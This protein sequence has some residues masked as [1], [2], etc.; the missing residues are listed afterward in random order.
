MFTHKRERGEGR[1][2]A[3]REEPWLERATGNW[4]PEKGSGPK[5]EKKYPFLFFESKQILIVV[6]KKKQQITSR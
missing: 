2:T 6:K 5:W 4:G 1:D 3:E